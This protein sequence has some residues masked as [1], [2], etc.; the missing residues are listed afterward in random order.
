MRKFILLL[1]INLLAVNTS[2][3]AWHADD[4]ARTRLDLEGSLQQRDMKSLR[5]DDGKTILTW[6]RGDR[7]DDH[8]SSVLH[9]QIFDKDGNA[10]FGDEGII[11]C[12]KPTET[13]SNGYGLA[14]TPDGDIVILYQDMRN[15][16]VNKENAQMF[17]YR[18]NQQGQPVWD[19]D[20]LTLTSIPHH[21]NTLCVSEDACALCIGDNGQIYAAIRQSEYLQNEGVE[22]EINWQVVS[23]ND[24]GTVASDEPVILPAKVLSLH[25]A[26]G[27]DAFVIYD[28]D[29]E[30][31]GFEA[32]RIDRNLT[33]QWQAPAIVEAYSQNEGGLIHFPSIETAADGGIILCYRQL[34]QDVSKGVWV[35]NHLTP[36][37][38]VLERS[39]AWNTSVEGDSD[40]GI[41]AVKGNDVFTSWVIRS[42]YMFYLLVNQMDADGNK[43]WDGD[44]ADGLILEEMPTIDVEHNEWNYGYSPV[45]AIPVEDG[46]VLLYGICTDFNTANFM[47][48][49]F[50]DGGNTVWSRQICEDNF[51]SSGFSVCYD[52]QYAYIFFTQDVELDEHYQEIPGT[53]GMFVMCVDIT[54]SEGTAIDEVPAQASVAS[55]AIYTIDGKRVNQLQ[56]GIN[57]V[58]TTDEN[59][60]ISIKKIIK[61]HKKISRIKWFWSIYLWKWI[62]LTRSS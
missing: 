14:L 38:E 52:K 12:D 8:Y 50:D 49:K 4:M 3:A 59:G 6:I 37:G 5:S 32:Q 21:Y 53:G 41:M 11:V 34:Q 44:A 25:P 24:D 51:Q 46:W 36:E 20:G 28:G 54:G 47:L 55:T 22:C 43:M 61:Q 62:I 30:K 57:I 17:I 9:L 18:Y 2:F 13:S 56:Q 16:P 1:L 42:Q 10:Q 19:A 27:G 7:V 48:T 26:P 31:K 23:L 29:F 60:V 15:D 33:P 58:R 35:M 40:E 39:V 45:K